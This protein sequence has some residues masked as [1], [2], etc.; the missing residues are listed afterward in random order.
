MTTKIT[1]NGS[2]VA[3][4]AGKHGPALEAPLSTFHLRLRCARPKA[5]RKGAKGSGFAQNRYPRRRRVLLRLPCRY[6]LQP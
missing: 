5:E 1:G 6:H 2:P 3:N 4:H